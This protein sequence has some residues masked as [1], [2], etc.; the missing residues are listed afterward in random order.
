MNIN[1]FTRAATKALVLPLLLIT[2]SL[3][4]AIDPPKNPR[5]VVQSATQ[6][7]WEWDWVS[8]AA[9]FEITVDGQ[10][11]G[12]TRD[13]RFVSSDLWP[14]E[15]SMSVKA[16][17]WNGQYSGPSVTVKASTTNNNAP[18]ADVQSTQSSER[19][20]NT[21]SSVAVPGN[22]RAREV[23]QSTVQWQWD[24]TPGAT[25]YEVTIDGA[26]AGTTPDTQL[27]SQNLWPGEHSI[28]VRAITDAGQYSQPSD[29]VK[30]VVSDNFNS[31]STNTPAPPPPVQN[32]AVTNNP[33]PST[34]SGPIDPASYNYGEVYEK[35]GYELSF[36]D[37]FNNSNLNSSRWNTQLRWDGEFN[38]ERQEYRVINGEQQ[39]YVNIFSDDQDHLDYVVP[40]HNPFELNG[41]RL[42]IRAIR[43]PLKT[44]NNNNGHGP[45]RS[46]VEQQEFLSG[47]ISTYDKFTQ[48]Y[49]YFEARIKIPDHVGTFPAFW[50]HHQLRKYEGTR[51]TEIDIMENLGHA[52]WYIYNSFHYFNNVSA[53][54]DGDPVFV[55]P[56]P[57]G[58]IHTGIDYSQGYHTYAVE[59]EP[60]HVTW[61]IDGQQV[62]ELYND[63][64]DHENL[65]VILNMAMGGY[66]TN[67]PESSGGLGRN[68]ED[69][70]PNQN[71]LN[72]FSNP[73]LEIDYVRVYKKK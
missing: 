16:V 57:E 36:S 9:Q 26:N 11:R 59:W 12:L 52:P 13:P 32:D 7:Q 70:F 50:L 41:S 35:P 73:A 43:N 67:Y 33:V 10:N 42:A 53:T 58:Q 69:Y 2:S 54:R 14:G 34:D 62:S 18:V 61:F 72:S 55:K 20:S 56:Q 19:S 51:R 46:M 23:E 48:K 60:G 3:V 66:W 47:A 27:Y 8:D 40:N 17:D 21:S 49:G 25:Q 38:G 1:M 45:L 63:N 65:Y 44:N 64:V 4:H 6:I 5:A 30:I 68:T 29:T 24:W 22:V 15:H 71:D 37:E 28:T 31:T 39:F